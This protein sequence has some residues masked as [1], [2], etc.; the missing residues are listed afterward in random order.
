[1]ENFISQT[2]KS[3]YY[4]LCQI[5]SVWKYLSTSETGHLTHS[6]TPWLL[7]FSFLACLLPLS[8]AFVAY[9]IVPHWKNIKLTTSHL[10]FIFST[11]FQSNKEFSTKKK[12]Q[13]TLCYKY[14]VAELQFSLIMVDQILVLVFV[15]L[16]AG[17]F[18]PNLSSPLISHN[19]NHVSLT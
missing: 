1:M 17:L 9:R 18:A 16:V 11:G 10:C 4:Q 14:I 8:K 19:D 12:T 15:C 3:F 13:K 5:S 6:V 7:Q 2:T